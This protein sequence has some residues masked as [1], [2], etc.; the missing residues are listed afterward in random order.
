M[1]H[2]YSENG[3][4]ANQTRNTQQ[5]NLIQSHLGLVERLAKYLISTNQKHD[6]LTEDDLVNAGY[7]ALVEAAYTY[8]N[9]GEATFKT[10]ASHC[11]K[12]KM[13][14]EFRLMFPVRVPKKQ[15]GECSLVRDEFDESEGYRPRISVFDKY[16]MEAANSNWSTEQEELLE[17]VVEA[18]DR[19]KSEER[20][21]VH[22]RY[23]FEGESKRLRE[24]AEIYHISQQAVDK[25]LN[26]IQ[27]NLY[28]LVTDECHDYKLSA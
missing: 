15:W 7:E 21:L 9:T 6:W 23:G 3:R 10:Y 25:R 19:L 13:Y 17:E 5:D 14:A 2:S 27:D 26:K 4:G 1:T 28:R 24:L 11:I 20:E 22:Y 12:N 16:Q 18:K 8:N